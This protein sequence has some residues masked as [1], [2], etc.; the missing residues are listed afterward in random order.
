MSD[1]PKIMEGTPEV[2]YLQTGDAGDEDMTFDQLGDVT[3]ADDWIDRGDTKYIRADVAEREN[4][5]LRAAI[6]KSQDDIEQTLGRALGYP[7]FKDDQKNF[8]GATDADGVCVGDHVAESLAMEAASKISDLRAQLEAARKDAVPVADILA[9]AD[10][11]A[12]NGAAVARFGGQ[13]EHEGRC[14]ELCAM[15]LRE[16]VSAFRLKQQIAA[17]DAAIAKEGK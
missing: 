6:S 9:S 8:P 3:W 4:A 17:I 7:W 10:H 16:L 11:V 2:I 14:R 1:T 15:Y 12:E 5:D 13:H